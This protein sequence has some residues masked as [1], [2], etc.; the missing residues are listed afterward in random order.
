MIRKS[1]NV[2]K[3]RKKTFLLCVGCQKGGTTWLDKQLRRNDNVD[4]GFTKEYH[5]FDALYVKECRGFYLKKVDELRKTDFSTVENRKIDKNM[6][7]HLSFYLDPEKYFDY[8]DYLHYRARGKVELVGDITPSYGALPVEALDKIKAGLETRGFDVKVVFLLRDPLDRCWSAIRMS[9]KRKRIQNPDA[10][11]PDEN[12]SVKNCYSSPWVEIRSRYE[13]TIRNLEAVFPQKNIYYGVFEK[14]FNKKSVEELGQF[15]ELNN[16]N[17]DISEKI[18]TTKRNEASLN[19]EV[20]REVVNFYRDTYE[21]CDDKF[22]VRD[23]WD[24]FTYL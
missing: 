19:H 21:F 11:L 7:M 1:R 23:V 6:L 2:F 18:N 15:L 17:P 4:L 20:S 9:H 16:F 10:I 24:G 13:N 8:F 3:Q 5:V 14:F 22:G 12:I